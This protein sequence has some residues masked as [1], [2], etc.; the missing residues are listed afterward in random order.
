[1]AVLT[2]PTQTDTDA[3]PFDAQ[4]TLDGV[5]YVLRFQWSDRGDVWRLSIL[6]D[7][8]SVLVGGLA[9]RNNVALLLPYKADARLPQGE[10]FAVALT[11]PER[12]ARR[13]ELGARV[14]LHYVEPWA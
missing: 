10:L 4:V 9:L 14:V 13:E 11:E 6:D 8:E 7:T 2:I 5:G 12:D 3:E 1:M